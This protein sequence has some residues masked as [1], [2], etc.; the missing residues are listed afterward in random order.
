MLLVKTQGHL[1]FLFLFVCVL[2]GWKLW[3]FTYVKSPAKHK[4]HF[5]SCRWL[6][7]LYDPKKTWT[8]PDNSNYSTDA[9]SFLCTCCSYLPL[10]Q[11]LPKKFWKHALFF[12]TLKKSSANIPRGCHLPIPLPSF[13]ARDILQSTAFWYLR[14]I[15]PLRLFHRG[16]RHRHIFIRIRGW[17]VRRGGDLAW[18]RVARFFGTPWL[19]DNKKG[20]FIQCLL[21][22]IER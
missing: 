12:G 21:G 7:W 15:L 17:D 3:T 20:T 16:H 5:V 10:N 22:T 9:M 19:R 4:S 2:C 11:F 14:I 18:G 8:P 13:Q 6:W 1:G